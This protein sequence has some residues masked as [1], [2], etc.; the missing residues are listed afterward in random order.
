MGG[1]AVDG[2]Q[3]SVPRSAAPRDHARHVWRKR[4]RSTSQLLQQP[5]MRLAVAAE[6]RLGPEANDSTSNHD[7][8]LR[9]DIERTTWASGKALVTK[10]TAPIFQWPALADGAN[11]FVKVYVASYPRVLRMWELTFLQELRVGASIL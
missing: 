2:V 1:H 6:G 7:A 10:M 9:P 4:K 11:V 8:A 5:L 3:G